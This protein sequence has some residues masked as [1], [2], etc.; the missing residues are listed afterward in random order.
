MI[1]LTMATAPPIDAAD[2][3]PPVEETPR[4]ARVFEVSGSFRLR[5][6][7]VR[8]DSDA[9]AWQRTRARI[10]FRV[11]AIG[12][13]DR[14][15][16]V[17]ARLASGSDNPTSSNVDREDHLAKEMRLDQ[18]F[19]RW[20]PAGWT[21]VWGGRFANPLLENHLLWDKDLCPEGIAQQL[22][23]A[24]PSG[25]T[26]VA[27]LGG[28][29]LD[30]AAGPDNPEVWIAQTG[31]AWVTAGAASWTAAIAWY[32]YLNLDTVVLPHGGAANTRT[33]AGLLAHDFDIVALYAAYAHAG[34]L[35]LSIILEASDN[36]AAPAA[37]RGL[38][39]EVRL[40]HNR[41]RGDWSAAWTFQRLE[42]DATPD[43][44]TDSAWH[45][46]GANYAGHQ[47]RYRIS[48]RPGWHLTASVRFMEEIEGPRDEERQ[49]RVDSTWGF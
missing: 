19:V 13:L 47:L 5:Y 24:R 21:T 6:E 29:V 8:V 41:R 17:G 43:A 16:A 15:L 10:R 46:Q 32:D 48:L 27:N 23:F 28:F 2:L 35:P 39:A 36:L 40:G 25:T 45:D 22:V 12:T 30:H 44:L 49:M 7:N 11:G 9:G 14:R 33:A 3:A 34:R 37:S 4:P 38:G 20:S 18:M 42:R 26:L 1:G 31:A